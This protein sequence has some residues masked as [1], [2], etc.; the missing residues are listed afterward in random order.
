M[1]QINN[2]QQSTGG[3][4]IANN[5]SA[6]ITR[7]NTIRIDFCGNV[8]RICPNTQRSLNSLFRSHSH[9]HNTWAVIISGIATAGNWMINIRALMKL[10]S[11]IPADNTTLLIISGHLTFTG[12][13]R[14][15]TRTIIPPLPSVGILRIRSETFRSDNLLLQRLNYYFPHLETIDVTCSRSCHPPE[16]NLI[17]KPGYLIRFNGLY[18]D[19]IHQWYRTLNM[20]GGRITLNIRSFSYISN[21]DILDLLTRLLGGLTEPLT[22]LDINIEHNGFCNDLLGLTATKSSARV[23]AKKR[24]LLNAVLSNRSIK[25]FQCTFTNPGIRQ[26]YSPLVSFPWWDNIASTIDAICFLN[27]HGLTTRFL[28]V[29]SHLDEVLLLSRVSTDGTYSGLDAVFTLLTMF[30]IH[31]L[32]NNMP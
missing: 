31:P 28:E 3:E 15:S 9:M 18:L 8:S 21:D 10:L 13:S 27:S 22:I 16:D 1:A 19:Q 32:I 14:W 5:I 24:T 4:L 20:I 12:G 25:A 30:S 26:I 11:M 29:H 7:N 17:T 2:Q 23:V 6:W